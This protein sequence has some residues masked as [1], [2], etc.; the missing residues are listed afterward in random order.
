MVFRNKGKVVHTEMHI[1]WHGDFTPASDEPFTPS[2][3]IFNVIIDG[4]GSQEQDWL[5]LKP[6]GVQVKP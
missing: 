5:R 3:A 1:R 2:T 4:K 6:K